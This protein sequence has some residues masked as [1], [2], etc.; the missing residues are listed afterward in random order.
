MAPPGSGTVGDMGP[1]G[2]PEPPGDLPRRSL[3]IR[4][5][6]R[7]VWFRA[8]RAHRGPLYFNRTAGRF[9]APG[10]EFGTLYLGADEACSFIEAFNQEVLDRGPLGPIVSRGRLARCRLCPVTA[11]RPIRLVDLTNGAALR[12]LAPD[13]DNRINDGPHAVSQ[14]W[15]LAFW[16]HPS[17]PDGL[18][19]RSRRAPER[20]AVALFDRVAPVLVADEAENVLADPDRLAAILDAFGC[21]LVP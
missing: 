15:A 10:A 20:L 16:R 6:E 18:L 13:A 17:R 1:P 9:A 2:P 21:M 4:E 3:P 7:P 11:T 14:R 5:F 8:Y 19:Y 12:R